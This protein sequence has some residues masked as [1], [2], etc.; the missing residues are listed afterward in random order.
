MIEDFKITDNF[1][2]YEMTDSDR[3]PHL[4]E[5]NR[6]EAFNSSD[7]L[8]DLY[9]TCDMLERI[10]EH[11]G[12]MPVHISS[13]FRNKALNDAVGGSHR[14]QHLYGQAADFFV[15]HHDMLD[16]WEDLRRFLINDDGKPMYHQMYF[17]KER[18]FIHLGLATGYNDGQH[19]V[20]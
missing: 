12:D 9:L 20:Q 7:V 14:S 11:L 4:V 19:W 16:V 17:D 10:R 13:G 3:F 18:G 6:T 8:S 15:L 2:F 5:A 1:W